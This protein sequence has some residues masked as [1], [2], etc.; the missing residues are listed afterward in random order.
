RPFRLVSG[1]E[2]NTV[3]IFE[4]PPFK[5]KTVVLFEGIE[6]TKTGELVDDSVKG[7]AAHSGSV[8]GL[9]W[10]PCGQ[11]IATASGD[12]TVKI[13]NVPERALE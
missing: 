12:K 7:G 13:W 3:A 11:R 1:S 10:S 5:F 9:A 2:D 4:G 8:F 6:G